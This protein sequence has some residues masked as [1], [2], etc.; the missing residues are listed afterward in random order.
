MVDSG[1][2]LYCNKMIYLP[3]F[4]FA[5]QGATPT[6]SGSRSTDMLK[7]AIVLWHARQGQAQRRI[8]CGATLMKM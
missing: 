1:P 7:Y 3:I 5:D 6:K 4:P 8:L 2:K